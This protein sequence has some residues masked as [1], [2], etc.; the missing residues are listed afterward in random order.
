MLRVER[1][2]AAAG[3]HVRG[4]SASDSS[5]LEFVRYANFVI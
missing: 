3:R 4:S 5:M 2:A 1:A